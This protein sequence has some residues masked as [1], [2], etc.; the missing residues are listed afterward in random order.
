[1]KNHRFLGAMRHSLPTGVPS[2]KKRIHMYSFTLFRQDLGQERIKRTK[3]EFN[4][5]DSMLW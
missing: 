2:R 1:M 4:L 3:S 5:V